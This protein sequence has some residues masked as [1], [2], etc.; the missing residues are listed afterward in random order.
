V[1]I[2]WRSEPLPND[3]LAVRAGLDPALKAALAEAALKIDDAAAATL[4]PAHYTG[5]V[6]AEPD[7]YALIEAAGRALNLLKGA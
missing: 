6:A 4:L 5:W 7:S 2:V 3:A 1:K